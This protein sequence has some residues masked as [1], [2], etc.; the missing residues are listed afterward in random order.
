MGVV[1]AM[2]PCILGVLLIW[3]ALII[4]SPQSD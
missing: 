3:I 2:T 4:I 1:V